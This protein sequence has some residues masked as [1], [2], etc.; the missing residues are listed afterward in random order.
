MD[1]F[2]P[3]FFPKKLLVVWHSFGEIME[4]KV[5]IR[6]LQQSLS[7]VCYLR[8]DRSFSYLLEKHRSPQR[9]GWGTSP[10]WNRQNFCCRIFP[11]SGRGE[12]LSS[13]SNHFHVFFFI[14]FFYNCIYF[15]R[16]ELKEAKRSSYAVFSSEGC[17][18]QFWHQFLSPQ[19]ERKKRHVSFSLLYAFKDMTQEDGLCNH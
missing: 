11:S 6:R 15:N 9:K 4:Q 18:F 14:K 7:G 17:F 16:R 8:K 5:C 2:F 13:Q 19:P 10:L 12:I 3:P 1:A